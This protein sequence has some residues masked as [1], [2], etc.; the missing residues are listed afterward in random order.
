MPSPP[1][2]QK[3]FVLFTDTPIRIRKASFAFG[4]GKLLGAHAEP[5]Y[6]G[7]KNILT[8]ANVNFR[9][10]YYFPRTPHPWPCL[11]MT[12][13]LGGKGDDTMVKY[14]DLPM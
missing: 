9:L 1:P 14:S 12:V 6:A 11:T 5:W 3:I 7:K 4:I 8:H 10:E 2:P 13:D